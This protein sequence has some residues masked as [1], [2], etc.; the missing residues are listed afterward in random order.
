MADYSGRTLCSRHLINT[1]KGVCTIVQTPFPLWRRVLGDAFA[2]RDL[3]I[4][5]P[6][7]LGGAG[8][9][10]LH[11]HVFDRV[12]IGNLS[13]DE[14][15]LFGR[16]LDIDIAEIEN[17]RNEAVDDGSHVLDPGELKLADFTAEE[18]LLLDI[19]DAFTGDNPDVEVVIYPDEER[20][21]PEKEQESI[22]Q[23]SQEDGR[24]LIWRKG[25]DLRKDGEDDDQENGGESDG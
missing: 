13:E 7:F 18:A 17:G 8:A 6:G 23:K 4:D 1:R 12:G 11:H 3:G 25:G 21:E 10:E 24:E 20:I 14:A 19:D 16:G 9:G 15:S 5:S 22:E 2:D